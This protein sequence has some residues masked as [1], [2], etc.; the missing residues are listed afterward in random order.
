MAFGAPAIDASEHSLS[1]PHYEERTEIVVCLQ[2]PA[3]PRVQ[4]CR[5]TRPSEHLN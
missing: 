2:H 1:I 5:H 4:V 3:L